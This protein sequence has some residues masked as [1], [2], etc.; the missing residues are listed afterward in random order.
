MAAGSV[1][2]DDGTVS[3]VLELRLD[4]D[5]PATDGIGLRLCW[6]FDNRQKVQ[7]LIDELQA[8]SQQLPPQ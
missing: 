4:A 7:E 1:V 5:N 2:L 3:V 8:L 6:L